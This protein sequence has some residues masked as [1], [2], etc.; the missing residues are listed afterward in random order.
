MNAKVDFEN[1][2]DAQIADDKTIIESLQLAQCYL[3]S[4]SDMLL[5]AETSYEASNLEHKENI[6]SLGAFLSVCESLA[7]MTFQK[8]EQLNLQ[9][10][11]AIKISEKIYGIAVGIQELGS[12]R[13]NISE[14]CGVLY[15]LSYV[16]KHLQSELGVI[17]DPIEFKKAI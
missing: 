13:T 8:V 6:Q 1:M 5:H 3:E 17:L 10:L 2:A 12:F 11:E 7:T 15:G 4:L 14:V 9:S 16:S